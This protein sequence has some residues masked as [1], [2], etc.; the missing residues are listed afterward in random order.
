MNILQQRFFQRNTV[1]VA[2]DLLGCIVVRKY[3]NQIISGKIIETEAYTADDPACHAYRGKT[4]RNAAL[5]GQVGSAYVYMSY[6]LHY[7]LNV[8]AREQNALAG[9]VLIRALQPLEGI[10]KMHILRNKKNQKLLTNGPGNVTQALG[11]T[12][13]QNGLALNEK[14]GLWIVQPENKSIID[15]TAT[16]RIGISVAQ[17]KLWRFLLKL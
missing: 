2:Q 4:K 3:N 10:E 17:D 14:N 8:V 11:V 5:F 1:Q 15:I 6:G 16:P 9:G 12:I 7:C 13:E